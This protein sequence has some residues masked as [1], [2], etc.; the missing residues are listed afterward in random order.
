M[1]LK[2]IGKIFLILRSMKFGIAMLIFIMLLSIVGSVIPQGQGEYFYYSMYSETVSNIILSLKFDNIFNSAL[3]GAL[4]L[5]LII[6][7]SMCSIFRFGRI[8]K[9]LNS[10]ISIN[11]ME[12]ICV[13]NIE[14][15]ESIYN[16]IENIFKKH[17]FYKY[18]KDNATDIY[19]SHKNKAGYF[20]SWILHFGILL[21]IIFYTYGNMTFFSEGVYGVPGTVQQLEGTEYKVR[22]NDFKVDYNSDGSVKQYTSN[23]DLLDNS[24]EK[25]ES[26]S[27]SVNNP[28]RFEGYTFYQTSYG[29]AANISI[30]KNGTN[31]LN[32]AIYEKTSLNQPENNIAIYFNS[33]FPDFAASTNGFYSKS[34]KLNNPV[35]LYS[36]YYMGKLVKMNIASINE[37]IKWN[38]YEFVFHNPEQ[39]TYLEVNKMNGQTGAMIGALLIM[40]GLLMAFYYRPVSMVIQIEDNILYIYKTKT[41]MKLNKENY[42]KEKDIC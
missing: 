5:L 42:Q 27:T 33:F 13:E 9:K 14:L 15:R 28:V 36:F 3:F 16:K 39:Y 11:S 22:I 25:L 8:I 40:L 37:A 38:E 2:K 41:K 17:G 10:N 6:N 12:L 19:F 35:V 26:S 34:E 1:I 18:F 4:F 24:G 23:I 32:E 29:W 21:V 7:L 30:L 20:G 31:V